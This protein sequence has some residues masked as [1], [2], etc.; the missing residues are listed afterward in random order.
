M[1]R[2]KSQLVAPRWYRVIFMLA[3]VFSPLA[4]LVINR[5]NR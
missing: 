2:G 3:R 4:R 1:Q 5:Q